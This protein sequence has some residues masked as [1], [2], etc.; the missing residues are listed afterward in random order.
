[1]WDEEGGDGEDRVVSSE[2]DLV[3]TIPGQ[4]VQVVH[5]NRLLHVLPH[6]LVKLMECLHVSR[7]DKVTKP[8]LVTSKQL[9]VVL[10]VVMSVRKCEY[11]FVFFCVSCFDVAHAWHCKF[12]N[13][14]CFCVFINNHDIRLQ[15]AGGIVPPPGASKPGKSLY[16]LN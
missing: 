7:T 11:L 5:E 12:V 3:G 6:Q 16:T 9:R 14:Q 1:M 4:G 15:V 8:V 2:P 13:V 10:W